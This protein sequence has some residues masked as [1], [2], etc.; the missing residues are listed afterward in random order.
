M[1]R[2]PAASW[3]RSRRRAWIACVDQ[4]CGVREVRKKK[5]I[6]D[7]VEEAAWRAY[8]PE[9]PA[10]DGCE[11]SSSHDGDPLY[12]NVV[13]GAGMAARNFG[14]VIAAFEAQQ[15][16]SSKYQRGEAA[17]KARRDAMRRSA[18]DTVE[19]PDPFA[20]MHTNEA[21]LAPRPP[22]GRESTQFSPAE[23]RSL[24]ASALY[25]LREMPLR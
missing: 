2:L 15:R 14:R 25:L 19:L 5:P 22:I 3:S 7:P 17:Y 18:C 23:T 12:A 16:S 1:S 10:Q 8:I 6:D 11:I 24:I 4:G 13:S 21:L 20:G 9:L